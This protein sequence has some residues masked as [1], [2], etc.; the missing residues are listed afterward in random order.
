M[1]EIKTKNQLF[2]FITHL[3]TTSV[4]LLNMASRFGNLELIKSMLRKGANIESKTGIGSTVLHE[5]C[6]YG[7]LEVTKLLVENGATIESEDKYGC[8]PLHEA[9]KYGQ[10]EVTKFLLE[11]GAN[12]ESKSSCCERQINCCTP[13]Y[14]A[15]RYAHLEIMK[16]LLQKGANYTWNQDRMIEMEVMTNMEVIMLLQ[17]YIPSIKIQCFFRVI[18]AKNIS[19]RLRME[20]HNLFDPEFSYMRKNMFKIDDSRFT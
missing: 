6:K 16:F 2:Q 4:M 11:K 7:H 9:C 8:T 3:F 5:A 20:P 10:L 14:K 12:I 17:T 15:S 18:A 13:L 19:N 1:V